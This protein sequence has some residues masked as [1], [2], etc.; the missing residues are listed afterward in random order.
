MGG[1][2]AIDPGAPATSELLDANGCAKCHA[3]I[4]AEW[5][6]S[7]HALAW[8]NGIF[9]REYA[10]RPQP[11][12]VNCH[13]P[14]T[15]Q[16]ANIQG[17]HAAQ[18]VDC[19]TCHVRAGKLVSA[20]KAATSPHATIVDASFGSPAFCAD[21]HEFTFPVLSE[22][23]VA[24]AMTRHPMQNTVASFT[25][26]PYAH[27]RDGC[28][29]CHGSRANHAFP[30][31]HDPGMREAA[32]DIAWCRR[33]G[34][35][36]VAITNANAGHSV[37][38]GDVHRH[39]Y[40]RVWKSSAPESMFQAFFGRRFELVADGGKRT[41]WDS[42]IAPAAT[43]RFAIAPAELAGDEDEAIN[44]ELV[45][46]FVENEFPRQGPRDDAPTVSLARRRMSF[47]ALPACQ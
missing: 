32:L 23:G 43:K 17:T 36:E 1:T 12:C 47:A 15:T 16:Q 29:T 6:T 28:M 27:Q 34:T 14:L 5:S 24:M 3:A 11:W 45:Y 8:T 13:A 26:G 41:I 21:C 46:V 33:E 19:A 30:G 20:S 22:R 10:A 44:L 42:T 4:V 35:I 18:G 38:T 31:G 25:A 37:P 39:M 9:Q 40:L 2:R 7:R